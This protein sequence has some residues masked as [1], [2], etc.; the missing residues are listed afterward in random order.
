MLLKFLVLKQISKEKI[1]GHRNIYFGA[2]LNECEEE[3]KWKS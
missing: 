1:L 2:F 3:A